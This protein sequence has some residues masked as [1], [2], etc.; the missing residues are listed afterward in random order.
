MERKKNKRGKKVC[1]KKLTEK[2]GMAM[3]HEFYLEAS[4]I[5]SSMFER[6]LKKLLCLIENHAP[7]TGVTLEQSIKRVKYLHV[8]S[9][10][11]A[12]TSH[13]N[14]QTIDQIRAWKNQRNEILKD[15]PGV[16]VSE[17]RMERLAS[18]GVKLYKELTKALKSFKSGDDF[19][20]GEKNNG[21]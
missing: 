17:V 3:K 1:G 12:L 10:Y 4:W 5:L 18:D 16:H 11:P 21:S 14:V 6:K 8:S 19:S 2:A 9:K 15:M 13:L 20:G 7:G